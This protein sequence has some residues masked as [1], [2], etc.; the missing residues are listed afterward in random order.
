[1]LHLQ[2][3]FSLGAVLPGVALPPHPLA[4]WPGTWAVPLPFP[5]AYA[6]G[7]VP[8]SPFGTVARGLGPYPS[9]FLG[10]APEVTF[11]PHPSAL[12]PGGLGRTPPCW[13]L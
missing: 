9:H 4:L 10:L 11:P 3:V 12:W 5:G 8:T 2:I 6:R 1:M 13:H 7:G